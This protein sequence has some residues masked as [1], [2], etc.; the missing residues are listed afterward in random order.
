MGFDAR[1]PVFVV[2]EQQRCLLENM[3]SKLATSK[4]SELD[5]VAELDCFGCGLVG[6]SEDRFCPI[7]THMIVGLTYISAHFFLVHIIHI[8]WDDSCSQWLT[9]VWL[10]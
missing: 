5:C 9:A 3:I 10:W 1:K 6:N 4:I 8:F 7:T 2:C